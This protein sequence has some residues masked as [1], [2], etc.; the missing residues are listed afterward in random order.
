[1][2]SDIRVLEKFFVPEIF[3]R[4]SFVTGGYTLGAGVTYSN[5]QIFGHS[6]LRVPVLKILQRG[7]DSSTENSVIILHGISPLTVDFFF[8][9]NGV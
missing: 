1:M 9:Q 8:F 3:L 4:S 5:F 2:V 6:P 7:D